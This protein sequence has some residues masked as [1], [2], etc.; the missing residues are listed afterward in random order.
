MNFTDENSAERYGVCSNYLESLEA[1]EEIHLFVRSATGFHIPK[2]PTSPV[3]LIGPGNFNIK[4]FIDI[5]V[6]N[7]KS[8][9]IKIIKGTGTAPFRGFWQEWD[10]LKSRDPDAKI[11]KVWLFFGCRTKALDLYRDEKEE[12]LEKRILDRTFLA[13]SREPNIPKVCSTIKI[14]PLILFLT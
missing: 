14:I 4:V 12:M 7:E 6:P 9:C 8:F 10:E 3:I 2:D 5:Y 13:L 11:P 1:N